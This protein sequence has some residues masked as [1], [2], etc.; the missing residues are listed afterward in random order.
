[1]SYDIPHAP[2]GSP[3]INGGGGIC[4]IKGAGKAMFKFKLKL[5]WQT[6]VRALAS[7][8]QWLLSLSESSDTKLFESPMASSSC[9]F[10]CTSMRGYT[11]YDTVR[12]G[13]SHSAVHTH[14]RLIPDSCTLPNEDDAASGAGGIVL[15]HCLASLKNALPRDE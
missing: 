3:K 9:C 8:C 6:E 4:T 5:K 12:V 13:Y 10:L 1:M 15:I 14:T 2:A 7:A 11:K